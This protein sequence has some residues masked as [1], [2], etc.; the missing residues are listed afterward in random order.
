MLLGFLVDVAGKFIVEQVS[1]GWG[2]CGHVCGYY[3]TRRCWSLCWWTL[4]FLMAKWAP[5][6]DIYYWVILPIIRITLRITLIS[7]CCN[8]VRTIVVLQPLFWIG[9]IWC[10]SLLF[11]YQRLRR[12]R[13]NLWS[14]R[15]IPSRAYL[16]LLRLCKSLSC[17][18]RPHQIS[19]LVRSLL[20]SL[21]GFLTALIC[22]ST[23]NS[24]HIIALICAGLLSQLF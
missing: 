8:L 24:C 5:C 4:I 11:L 9:S 1:R 14:C 22:F 21:E 16:S 12:H 20:L 2:C 6:N 17:K 18:E 3:W 23:W 13:F 10:I 19:F 15:H 7:H